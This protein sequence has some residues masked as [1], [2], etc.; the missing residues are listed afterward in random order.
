MRDWSS[1][2]LEKDLATYALANIIDGVL[3]YAIGRHSSDAVEQASL[4][5]ENIHDPILRTQLYERISECFV[6]VGCIN[7]QRIEDG[8]DE[9]FESGFSFL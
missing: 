7:F 2:L 9:D 4:I 3:K 6:K 5:A 1:T 8:Q